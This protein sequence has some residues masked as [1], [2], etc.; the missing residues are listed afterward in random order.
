MQ[1][2]KVRK[3]RTDE[4]S[5]IDS[6]QNKKVLISTARKLFKEKGLEVPL[7][8]IAKAAGVS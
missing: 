8:E 2:N 3:S 5:R 4:A 1:I 6:I 7:L